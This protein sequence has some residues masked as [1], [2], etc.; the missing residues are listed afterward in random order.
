VSVFSDLLRRLS[1][2]DADV[3]V[4]L[5]RAGATFFCSAAGEAFA[6]VAIGRSRITWPLSSS[7]FSEWL[8]HQFYTDAD[9]RKAPAAAAAFAPLASSP[10][11]ACGCKDKSTIHGVAPARTMTPAM[12][13]VSLPLVVSV[14]NTATA[15]F[16]ARKKASRD[17]VGYAAHGKKVASRANL[18]R[19][20]SPHSPHSP[21]RH[22][23]NGTSGNEGKEGKVFAAT[24]ADGVNSADAVEA[25]AGP[26]SIRI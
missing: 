23:G 22:S 26:W 9:R 10:S 17:V 8:L 5:G 4:R 13:R 2:K 18:P 25:T 1:E 6:D 16:D 14:A 3:L 21:A 15:G 12:K 11:T 7:E 20:H 19:E 24:A